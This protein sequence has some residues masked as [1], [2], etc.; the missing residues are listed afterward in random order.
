MQS[1]EMNNDTVKKKEEGG[2]EKSSVSEQ[3]MSIKQEE[4]QENLSEDEE[5]TDFGGIPDTGNFKKFLGCG[6]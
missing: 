3:K 5:G 2:T 4:L 1:N 6:G